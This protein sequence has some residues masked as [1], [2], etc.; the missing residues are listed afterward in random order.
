M[1][2]GPSRTHRYHPL[3][4]YEGLVPQGA[5]DWVTLGKVLN[6]SVSHLTQLYKWVTVPDICNGITL[7]IWLHSVRQGVKCIVEWEWLGRCVSL[8]ICKCACICIYSGCWLTFH[9]LKYE[10]ARTT[11][12]WFGC[13]CIYYRNIIHVL[14][15]WWQFNIHNIIVS[16]SCIMP[17]CILKLL[18]YV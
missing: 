2:A 12:P 10:I 11:Y 18:W 7:F 8:Q 3:C 15:I 5:S 17:L 16:C 1:K 13:M 9:L 14:N 4:L 6:A